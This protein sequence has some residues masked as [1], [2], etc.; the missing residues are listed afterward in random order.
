MKKFEATEEWYKKAAALEDDVEFMI[1]GAA[2]LKDFD[3]LEQATQ[4]VES[5]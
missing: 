1:G 4:E 5:L 3:L 2:L